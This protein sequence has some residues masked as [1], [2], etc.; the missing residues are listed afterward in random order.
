[1]VI[2]KSSSREYIIKVGISIVPRTSCQTIIPALKLI[3][4]SL[5]IFIPALLVKFMAL[6]SVA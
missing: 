6:V 4:A 5:F 2:Y 1:M 3:L